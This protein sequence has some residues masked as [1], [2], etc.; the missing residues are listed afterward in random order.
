M[1]SGFGCGGKTGG[2]GADYGD[3]EIFC[4]SGISRFPVCRFTTMP[5]VTTIMQA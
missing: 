5:S 1:R 3:V 4:H 2:S